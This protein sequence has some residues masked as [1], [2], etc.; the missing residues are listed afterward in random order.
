MGTRKAFSQSR[1]NY[2]KIIMSKICMG[3]LI[4][5]LIGLSTSSVVK[6]TAEPAEA[7]IDV[8]D[9][10]CPGVDACSKCDAFKA[11]DAHKFLSCDQSCSLC[12]LCSIMYVKPGCD[13]C[14][15]GVTDCKDNCSIGAVVCDKCKKYC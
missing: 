7:R 11:T 5:V 15:E 10:T 2:S 9:T 12:P 6:R 8:E 4:F 13:Y 1:L 14:K 3:L